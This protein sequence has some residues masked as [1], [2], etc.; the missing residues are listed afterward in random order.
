[1]SGHED[2]Y[3]GPARL[4]IGQVVFEVQVELRGHFEPIDGRYHW[5]GRIAKSEA[6]ATALR[7][8]RA[9]GVIQTPHGSG[10]CDVAEPD[11]W[12]RY[13]ITGYST[14]PYPLSAP[15]LNDEAPGLS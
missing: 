8:Q 9:A 13:R 2:G 4:T 6:L 5:Y 3:S 7:R 10:T 15:D 14:P 12:D 1:M 11:T